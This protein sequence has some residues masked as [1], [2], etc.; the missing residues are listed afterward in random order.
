MDQMQDEKIFEECADLLKTC[1]YILKDENVENPSTKK[2]ELEKL[3]EEKENTAK[4]LELD[5]SEKYAHYLGLKLAHNRLM[6]KISVI[7]KCT[8][9]L[10]AKNRNVQDDGKKILDNEKDQFDDNARKME[11]TEKQLEQL[12]TRFTESFLEQEIT[13]V[14]GQLET[15]K[16]DEQTI[17]E[18]PP[19]TVKLPKRVEELKDLATEIK[20]TTET[21]PGIEKKIKEKE[22][23]IE[24]LLRQMRNNEAK[25]DSLE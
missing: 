17:A 3:H 19:R 18:L 6:K 13:K 11:D 9:E 2:L 8:Q 22:S 24:F 10:N 1:T 4:K 21:V 20:S 12:Q 25:N 23:N 7:V 5:Q 16:Q 15:A 14:A